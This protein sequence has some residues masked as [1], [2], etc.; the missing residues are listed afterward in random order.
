MYQQELD[1]IFLNGGLQYLCKIPTLCFQLTNDLTPKLSD[2]GLARVKLNSSGATSTENGSYGT[3][4][5][6]VECIVDS[7]FLC[8]LVC[9]FPPICKEKVTN[10]YALPQY[11][12]TVCHT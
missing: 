2:F 10:L 3:I 12:V 11:I 5:V 8:F 6:S 7:S 4:L 1:N 9:G